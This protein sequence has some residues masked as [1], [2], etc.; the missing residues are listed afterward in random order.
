MT[1]LLSPEPE[2][3]CCLIY[4]N[5]VTPYTSGVLYCA[6]NRISPRLLVFIQLLTHILRPLPLGL[7]HVSR[8]RMPTRSL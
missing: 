2:L 5:R 3:L 1:V 7:A 4:Y 6:R 8:F